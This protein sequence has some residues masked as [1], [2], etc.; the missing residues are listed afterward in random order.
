[1]VARWLDPAHLGLWEV[2]VDLVTFAAYPAGIVTYW[3]T[4]DVARGRMVGRTALVFGML[5]SGGGLVIYAAFA[6]VTYSSLATSILPFLLAV[7]LVPLS[8]WSAVV[9]A[10]LQGHRPGAYGYS[11]ILSE[12]AKLGIAYTTLYAL[13]MGILGVILA[14]I[15]AYFVQSIVSSFFIWSTTKESASFSLAKRWTKLAWVPSFNSLYVMIAVADTYVASLGFGTAIAGYYQVAF[16][17]ASVVG[18]SSGL[19]FA[20][21]PLLLRGGG[22]RLPRITMEFSLLFSIPMAVGSLVLAEPMLF[23][24]RKIY[25]PGALGLEILS[26]MFVFTT[27]SGIIDQTLLGTERVDESSKAS[28]HDFFRSNL[29]FVPIM[30]LSFACTYLAAL[31]LSLYYSFSSGLSTSATVA[32]WASVELLAT[33]AFMLLKALR[34]RHYARLLPGVSVFYYLVAASVM[35]LIIHFLSG[36]MV[37]PSLSTIAYGAQILGLALVGSAIYFSVVFALDRKFRAMVHQILERFRLGERLSSRKDSQ[38]R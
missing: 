37:N 17:V 35:G 26:V 33:V 6:L 16:V 11:L 27:I 13:K 2:I 18:Y 34:A 22:E 12:F 4:R 9:N 28:F 19:A 1:M 21:Y 10:I 3:A 36:V 30:N 8:Y 24:F 14:L 29:L 31:Y 32:L 38:K 23:L 7:L 20:L 15:T 25:V 5:L